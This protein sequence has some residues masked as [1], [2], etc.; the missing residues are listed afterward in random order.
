MFVELVSC[1]ILCT[2]EPHGIVGVVS[3]IVHWQGMDSKY[4]A[5][6]DL[7]LCMT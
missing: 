4:Q 2:A 1:K 5:N 3:C 7:D 6:F